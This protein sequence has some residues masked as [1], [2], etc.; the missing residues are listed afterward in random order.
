[1]NRLFVYPVAAA[2][3]LLQSLPLPVVAWLGR[4]L[5]RCA[6]W[7]AWHERRRALVNLDIAFGNEWSKEEQGSIARRHFQLL[8]ESFL[9]TLKA[10]TME[11]GELGDRLQIVGL[12][13]LR[14]WIEQSQVPG[15]VV[16][17]GHFG[18]ISMYDFA[19]ADLPW[20]EVAATYRRPN[21]D[22]LNDILTGLRNHCRSRLFEEVED[23]KA[24]R[25]CLH[26]GNVVL[27]IMC[28]TNPG[29]QAPAIPFFGYPAATT[30]APALCA[31]RYRMPLHLAACYRTGPGR[32]RVEIGDEIPTRV[33]GRRRRL[34]DIMSDL[35]AQLETCIRRD[36]ANWCWVQPRWEHPGRRR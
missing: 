26:E 19:A 12:N 18:N 35:N 15:V 20:M 17:I 14:P 4:C 32:W 16:A 21:A 9:C 8:G 27:G 7:V 11:R 31:L 36:P 3:R 1:M 5:G 2:V 30:A 24:L 25:S 28:D 23:A 6:W 29:E 34:E 10:L 22:W 13:K 33:E